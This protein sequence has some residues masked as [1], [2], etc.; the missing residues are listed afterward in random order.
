MAP[1]YTYTHRTLLTGARK[2]PSASREGYPH[3]WR[4]IEMITRPLIACGLMEILC[5]LQPGRW[6][7]HERDAQRLDQ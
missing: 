2:P 7:G 1:L 3:V 6:I 5:P 4:R